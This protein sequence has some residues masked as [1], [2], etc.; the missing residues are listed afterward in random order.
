[1]H[2]SVLVKVVK[3][4]QPAALRAQHSVQ[5]PTRQE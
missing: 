1:M 2:Q 5:L 4:P 3:P